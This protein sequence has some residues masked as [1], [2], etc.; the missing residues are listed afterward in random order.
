[1]VQSLINDLIKNGARIYKP[2]QVFDQ[3]GFPKSDFVYIIMFLCKHAC[4]N[5]FLK[6][7]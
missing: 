7:I 3:V 1:M 5:S 6:Y 4:H 2:Q